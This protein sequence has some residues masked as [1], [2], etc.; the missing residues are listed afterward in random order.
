MEDKKAGWPMAQW[1][2]HC[3]TFILDEADA[4]LELGF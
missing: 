3:T 1:M 2:S 4:M